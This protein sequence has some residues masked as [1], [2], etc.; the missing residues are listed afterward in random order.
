MEI[1]APSVLISIVTYNSKH[2]FKVL[3]Q[4]KSEFDMNK[5][6]KFVVFDNNSSIEYQEELKTYI[7]FISVNFYSEIMVL[8]LDITITYF[9]QKKIIF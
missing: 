1:A 5:Q 8:D 7:P 6:F 2:I 3:D 4:L 9:R